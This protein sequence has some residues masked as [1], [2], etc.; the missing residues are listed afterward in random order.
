MGRTTSEGRSLKRTSSLVISTQNTRPSL[1]RCLQRWP[2]VG[3]LRW[4]RRAEGDIHQ[5]LNVL[6]RTDVQDGHA[7]KLLASVIVAPHGR[8]VDFQESQRFLVKNPHRM[9]AV[10]K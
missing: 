7:K 6:D 3:P 4:G 10:C 9:R 5:H 1:R 2:W 8:V